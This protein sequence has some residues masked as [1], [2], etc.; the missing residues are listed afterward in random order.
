MCMKKIFKLVILFFIIVIFIAYLLFNWLQKNLNLEGI[1]KNDFAQNQISK[2]LDKD[3]SQDFFTVIPN[4]LGFDKSK[5]YLVLFLNDTELRPGGGFIGSY[6]T[7]KIEKG[8]IEILKLEGSEKL[9]KNTPE[10][11][12]PEPPTILKKELG[13]DRWYFRDSNW[14]ADFSV[15]AQKALEF[16]SAEGGI[17]AENIDAV[18]AIDTKVL[19]E[20]LKLTGELEV[21]GLKFDSENVVEKLEYEVEYAFSD[22]GLDFT[23]RK[24]ILRDLAEIILKKIKTDIFFKA[25]DYK[26][27]LESMIN[28]KHIVAYFLNEDLN[29]NLENFS[30]YDIYGKVKKV[31]Q[32]YLLW[33]DANLAALKTDHAIS[34]KIN[35]QI[36]KKENGQYIA[37]VKMIYSHN[38][39][40]DWRTTRYRTYAKILV[41]KDSTLLAINSNYDLEKITFDQGLELDKKY[42]AYFFVIEPG[43][44]KE[45]E[46]EYLLSQE[47]A[48]NIEKGQY[49]LF[50]QKQIGT[51][52][53]D[54]TLSLKFDKNIVS[55][56]PSEVEENWFDNEYFLKTDLRVDREIEIF[57]AN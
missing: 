27:L 3:L 47:I 13:V 19:E 25:K 32:D 14:S 40:F 6:A 21:D 26:N 29:K 9:D 56:I 10:D 50:V 22:K 23:E 8:K 1:L 33:V 41:N 53:H 17:E 46:F 12:R 31:D 24:D 39:V 18:I 28:E 35:Y 37:K 7:L 54:L 45:L 55:A 34:R 16:Y 48:Q 42:F 11:W 36:E 51:N 49:N 15:S 57:L 30:D 2:I 20:I 43:Q 52:S 5:T 38:G 4:F 44:I